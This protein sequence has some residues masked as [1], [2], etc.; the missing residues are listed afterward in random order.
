MNME[1]EIRLPLVEAM[2]LALDQAVNGRVDEALATY[3]AVLAADPQNLTALMNAGVLR[4]QAGTPSAGA[5]MLERALD[6]AP[7]DQAVRNNL[8]AAYSQVAANWTVQGTREQAIVANR[9]LLQLRPDQEFH[10]TNLEA[11]LA[12][13]D[14]RALLSDYEPVRTAGDIGRTILIACMPKSGSSWLVNA[15]TA[16]SG[17]PIAHFANAFLENEQELYFPA[18][19][20]HAAENSVVQQHCR[21]SAPN[22]HLIQ[23]YAMTPVVLVRNLLDTLISMRDFWDAGAVRNSFLYPDWES[24][25]LDAKHDALVRHLAPWYI[26]FYVSWAL[27]DRKGDV[28]LLW[29]RYEDM[30]PDKAGTLRRIADFCGLDAADAQ[31]DACIA[32]VDG[33]RAR[34]RFNKGIAGRGDEAFTPVQK[35]LVRDLT[36]A[37][38]SIDFS[39][40]G[41]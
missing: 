14:G 2:Q 4:C 24:L 17:Y 3:G 10:R 41:L 23:A 15:M 33:D 16:L 18:V 21:A 26:Q 11:V 34:T 12:Y 5:E 13:T 39:P 38:P 31:I 25:D 6:L 1:T 20:R 28:E 7:N 8:V 22:I 36:R 30:I 32:E 37:F 27:A 9:R 35:D 29:V 40:I 19:R